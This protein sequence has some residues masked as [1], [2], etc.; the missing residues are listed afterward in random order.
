MVTKHRASFRIYRSLNGLELVG[1]GRL[2]FYGYS[3]VDLA[4][5]PDK[6]FVDRLV[7]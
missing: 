6:L 3:H 4:R 7:R 5:R 1:M 2:V